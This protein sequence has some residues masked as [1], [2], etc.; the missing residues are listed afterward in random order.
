MHRDIT[1]SYE[2]EK[3]GIN[4]KLLI[5]SVL[6]A[7][8]IAMVVIDNEDRVILDNHNYK[9]LVSDLDKG[10]PAHYFLKLLRN[11]MGDLW[12]ELQGKE[13]GFNNREYKVQRRTTYALVFVRGQLVY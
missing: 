13:Q 12:G 4:Q 7:S 8:P 11:E 6:N 10:E 3:K 2:S 9:A 5:E 1:E